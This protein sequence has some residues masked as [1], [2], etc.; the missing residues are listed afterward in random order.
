[1]SMVE[2]KIT[3]L[4]LADVCPYPSLFTA[5]RN[6]PSNICLGIVVDCKFPPIPKKVNTT[7]KRNA[8]RGLIG[9]AIFLMIGFMGVAIAFTVMF[10]VKSPN[11]GGYNPDSPSP[12]SPGYALY[13][14]TRFE[15]CYSTPTSTT[16][17]AAIRVALNAS[18]T[19]DITGFRDN[20]VGFL[21]SDL[22]HNNDSNL[23]ADWC[24]AISC[25][26]EYKVVPSSPRDLAFLPTV[27]TSWAASAG[28]LV[29]S[30]VQL[31]LQQKALYS[32][33][34]K[35]CKGLRDIH[36]YSWPFIIADL[37]SFVWWWI[38]FGKLVA[39]PESAATP[40]V[41]GWVIPW[42]YAGLF[43]F[44]PFSCAFGKN[45]R[46][47]LVTR[48]IFYT[49]AVIQYIASC[50][51]A[52]VNFPID[53]LGNTVWGQRAPHPSYDCVQSQID[54]APGASTCSATEICS[55][56]WLFVDPMYQFT[57]DHQYS[58]FAVWFIFSML[59]FAI[60]TPVFVMTVGLFE[61]GNS[62][63]LN[64]LRWGDPGPIAIL[65]FL[66]FCEIV[67]GGLLIEDIVDR[68]SLRPYASVTL[69]W[70]CQAIHVGMSSW[71]YY[72]DVH[73]GQGWR[74]A[75]MWFNS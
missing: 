54:A 74:I 39:A 8:I 55:R 18:V 72:I 5:F 10:A 3:T 30:L 14:N 68:L 56:N 61:R 37:C 47:Q 31:W 6:T 69:D 17:C 62:S 1:M 28:F 41:V 23:I 53:L 42:K 25:F 58:I 40:F 67:V 51:V 75:K 20:N 45:R 44:H 38:S 2:S 16:D 32:P 50:Y 73:Y 24:E 33:E 63:P 35:P 71:R 65:S 27:L 21:R 22:V 36:W 64:Y 49:L 52:H 59:T 15:E 12:D 13:K 29:G 70:E 4:L 48:W 46:G 19:D 9:T 34:N 7:L 11:F 66:S 60:L 43:R 26:D 57:G